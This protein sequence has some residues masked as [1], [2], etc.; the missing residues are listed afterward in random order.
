MTAWPVIVARL[1]ELLPTLDGWA[2]VEVYDGPPVTRDA[3]ADYCTVG[4]VL[5]EDVAGSY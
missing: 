3:P 4:F 1:L 2:G 5:D